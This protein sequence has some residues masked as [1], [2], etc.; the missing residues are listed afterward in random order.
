MASHC[1]HDRYL[2]SE[3]RF[4]IFTVKA[5]ERPHLLHWTPSTLPEESRECHSDPE[6]D[7]SPPL[8]DGCDLPGWRCEGIAPCMND[9]MCNVDT[10][11]GPFQGTLNVGAGSTFFRRE[12]LFPFI[13]SSGMTIPNE[14]NC[15][16]RC[17]WHSAKRR[18]SIPPSF[19]RAAPVVEYNDAIAMVDYVQDSQHDNVVRKITRFTFDYEITNRPVKIMN[20]TEGWDAMPKYK[21]CNDVKQQM[22]M[23]GWMDI[24]PNNEDEHST[25]GWTYVPSILTV[26]DDTHHL[27]IRLFLLQVCQS[28]ISIWQRHVPF[29]RSTR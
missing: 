25:L 15:T 14:E 12:S 8:T 18:L 9:D 20:A 4:E 19:D 27:T 24:L 1:I 2:D 10:S 3:E 29:L 17:W 13:C 7:V 28:T 6:E 11:D 16:E 23:H 22:T 5:A 26:F 21:A